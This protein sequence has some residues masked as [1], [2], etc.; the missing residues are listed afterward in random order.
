MSYDIFNCIWHEHT[1]T[2]IIRYK[3]EYQKNLKKP[4][5]QKVNKIESA[6]LALDFFTRPKGPNTIKETS[7]KV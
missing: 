4:V 6:W 7:I 1:K 2:Q 5:H 3:A